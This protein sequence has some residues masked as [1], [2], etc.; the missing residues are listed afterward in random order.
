M[1]LHG[2][3]LATCVATAIGV[4]TCALSAAADE[5]FRPLCIHG[6]CVKWANPGHELPLTL[7][8][9]IATADTETADA[10]NCRRMRPPRQLLERSNLSSAD[11]RRALQTAFVA[12]ERAA[13]IQFIEIADPESADILIGEQDVPTG[14]AFTN[15]SLVTTSNGEPSI[16]RALICLNPAK[17]WKIGYDGDLAVYDLVHTFAHEIGHSIG[18]DHP[19]QRGHLMSFRY[20]EIRRGLSDGDVMGA[21]S[22]YGAPLPPDSVIATKA[23]ASRRERE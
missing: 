4:V 15:V 13:N 5:L 20:D 8:W 22:L 16:G 14:Y 18:L 19:D 2:I 17:R 23:S 3:G 11:L 9:S 1:R 7:K 21:V 12:W 10:H 6:A